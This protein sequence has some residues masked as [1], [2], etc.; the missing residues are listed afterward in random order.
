MQIPFLLILTLVV[1]A[2]AHLG[3]HPSPR[4]VAHHAALSMMCADN[5]GQVGN[6]RYKRN[7]ARRWHDGNTTTVE[8]TTEA[9]Y[10]EIIHN[11][12]YVLTP[13]VTQGPYVWPR[14]QTLRQDMT[15][16][17]PG[18]PLWLDVGV[19]DMA[20]CQPL[21]NVL[22]DFWHCNA[23][24]SYSSFTGLSPDTPFPQLLDK[25]GI[26]MSTFEIGKTD[27]HTDNTTFLRGM[28]PTDKNGV[29]EMKTIFP[30]FYVL[31]TIHIHVQVHTNWTLH[32]NGTIKTA[33]TV[34]TGQIYFNEDLVDKLMAIEPYVSHTAINRTTNA[35]DAVFPYDFGNEYN[36]VVSVVPIDGEDVTK[37]MVGYITIGV[38]TNAVEYDDNNVG[39]P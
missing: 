3:R 5:V 8:V 37:G 38:D 14:S 2:L 25:L 28:W 10:Y 16:G 18:V 15:E 11:D 20:T 24:G 1:S 27:L 4:D 22:V 23:T 13:E 6:A 35:A 21:P 26:P 36:P 29:M 32:A 17:Q 7:L 19:V 34:S 30:G 33:N 12:T 31:R 9:P 39:N